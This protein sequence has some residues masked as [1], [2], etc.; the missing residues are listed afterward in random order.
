MRK[1]GTYD[2][3][4]PLLEA[5]HESSPERAMKAR[6]AAKAVKELSTVR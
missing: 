5:L 3:V 6:E 4:A 2:Q 1:R